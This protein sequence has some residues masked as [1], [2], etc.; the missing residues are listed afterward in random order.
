MVAHLLL[1]SD[2]RST[3]TIFYSAGT[4][5]GGVIAPWLFGRL[6]D[7][8]SKMELLGGY[9]IASA[10]MLGAALMEITLGIAAEETSLEK[11]AAPLSSG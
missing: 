2:I 5:A 9:A 11:I 1:Q 3:R 8:G 6:I 7:S 10:L 4:A